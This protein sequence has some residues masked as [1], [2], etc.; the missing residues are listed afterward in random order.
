MNT[1]INTVM[2]QKVLKNITDSGVIISLVLEELKHAVPVAKAL[3]KGGVNIIELTLRTPVAMDAAK[4]IMDEVPEATVG[5]GT[6]LTIDQVEAC[7][8]IGAHFAVAPGCNPRIIRAAK[9]CNLSFA[10][11]IATP[12]DIE[13]AIEE[14]CR[15]LKYFPAE[16][17]GGM[18]HLLNMS[19]PYKHLGL[20][21][22]PL[23]GINPSN[24]VSYLE[25]PL[26]GAIGGSW[27]AKNDMIKAEA[28]DQITQNA[29][30]I[31]QIINSVRR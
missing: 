30:E 9:D 4:A 8:E 1:E 2:D 13:R 20:S 23:G 10:P 14:N 29:K 15:V 6:V 5:F 22:L 21:F 25:S 11:G 19:A 18:K 27:I 31:K 16:T 3:I 26:I 28:W 7:S 17:S 24:V 12:S